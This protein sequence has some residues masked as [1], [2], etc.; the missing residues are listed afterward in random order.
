MS[1]LDSKL[2]HKR[3]LELFGKFDMLN[4]IPFV[5]SNMDLSW[6][7]RVDETVNDI[8]TE[9]FGSSNIE[10]VKINSKMFFQYY[11]NKEDGTADGWNSGFK[12]AL[13]AYIV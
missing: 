5:S 1:N 9:E 7:K 3:M 12:R 13:K 11:P 10:T 6:K 8:L 4:V 2:Y